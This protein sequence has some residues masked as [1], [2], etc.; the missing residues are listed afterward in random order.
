MSLA[1]SSPVPLLRLLKARYVHGQ[2][3]MGKA[4]GGVALGTLDAAHGVAVAG[5]RQDAEGICFE[6]VMHMRRVPSDSIK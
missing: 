4:Q 1:N 5:R 6:R 2:H 3:G